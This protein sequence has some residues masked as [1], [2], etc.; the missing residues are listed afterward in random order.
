MFNHILLATDASECSLNAATQSVQLAAAMKSQL[1]VIYVSAPHFYLDGVEKTTFHKRSEEAAEKAFEQIKAL[2]PKRKM[3][4]EAV[5]TIFKRG[6]RPSTT[7][8]E[9]AKSIGADLIV[10]G[11]HGH[12]GL[13][14]LMLGS[15]ANEVV[16]QAKCAVLITK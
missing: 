9:T 11:S 10:M 6:K 4:A 12:S 15:V 7:I 13:N 1:T 2:I 8:L 16:S 5:Q 14:R 3:S